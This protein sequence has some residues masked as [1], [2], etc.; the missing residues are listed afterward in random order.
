MACTCACSF[1]ISRESSSFED[2]LGLS[3]FT[4]RRAELGCQFKTQ[5]P[6]EVPPVARMLLLLLTTRAKIGRPWPSR[7][8]ITQFPRAYQ[9]KLG[10]PAHYHVLDTRAT[11]ASDV[12]HKSNSIQTQIVLL[13]LQSSTSETFVSSIRGTRLQHCAPIRLGMNSTG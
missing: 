8:L 1:P 5:T 10:S 12:I 2:S 6:A 4:A 11:V 3:H 7:H 13:V 9:T